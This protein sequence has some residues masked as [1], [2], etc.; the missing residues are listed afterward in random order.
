[1]MT[2]LCYLAARLRW[3]FLLRQRQWKIVGSLCRCL[4]CSQRWASHA[5]SMQPRHLNV[6]AI[7][8]EKMK[9]V[10]NM[11]CFQ[12][13]GR[14]ELICMSV[15]PP[16]AADKAEQ[17]F[18]ACEWVKYWC[19]LTDQMLFSESMTFKQRF[20]QS[21]GVREKETVILICPGCHSHWEWSDTSINSP[22]STKFTLVFRK[23]QPFSSSCR[24]S[25]SYFQSQTCHRGVAMRQLV[26]IMTI[27]SSKSEELF[28]SSDF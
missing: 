24:I 10:E 13:P 19:E 4:A 20:M 8:I 5:I 1:M 23:A 7:W 25:Q 6:A 9:V 17:P 28:F 26:V 16:L 18:Y 12:S 11:M 21:K 14:N 22:S 15:K 3:H 27:Y 2:D